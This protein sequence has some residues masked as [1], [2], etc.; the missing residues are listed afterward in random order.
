MIFVTVGTDHHPFNRLIKK[1]DEL[2]GRKKLEDTVFIQKGPALYRPRFCPYTSFLAFDEIM[3]Y[4]DKARIVVT[5]GGPG[6]IM[7]VLYRGKIP[8]VVPRRKI[9]G[10]VID[11]HQVAF[12]R[13]L[14]RLGKVLLVEDTDGLE[15]ILQ[16]YRDRV[17]SLKKGFREESTEDEG[18]QAFIKALEKEL[19]IMGL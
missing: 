10:E 3:E 19:S 6:S 2:A 7:P 17:R 4:I 8:V 15:E 12:S 14:S 18:R 5:H 13:R 16:G 1:M 11:D 9:Y